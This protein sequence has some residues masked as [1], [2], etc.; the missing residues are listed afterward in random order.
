VALLIRGGYPSEISTTVWRHKGLGK[1]VKYEELP[2]WVKGFIEF[3][4]RSL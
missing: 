4:L 2:S 3:S 1:K